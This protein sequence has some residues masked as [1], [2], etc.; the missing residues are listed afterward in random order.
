MSWDD[1]DDDWD[2]SDSEI[3]ARL[4]L[5]TTSN[6]AV[7]SKAPVFDDEEEDL[8]LIEQERNAK[9]NQESLR[10]KGKTLMKK[11]Q[12]ELDR[13][14][15]EELARKAMELEAEMEANM[16]IDE[17]R[18]ME[19]R[20]VEEADNA[21]TDDL[22]GAVESVRGGPGAGKG[23][24]AG[25][26][27]KMKDLK[28]HLKHARKVA[29][30]LTSNG[31][32]HLAT[33]FFKECIQESKD[34]LDDDAITDIIKICNVIKNEKLQ[35]AKR[36]VKGQAQKSKKKDKVAEKKAK[37]M[38]LEIYGDNDQCD[39]YDNFGADYEDDFF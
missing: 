23:M 5:A 35:A 39:D 38:A 13:K 21:L 16:T 1:S 12:A 26:T 7:A 11:K 27:V 24:E 3:D 22:F 34:I 29:Q 2:K 28:D 30:C 33:S 25:D 9:V 36:K 10:S 6:T 37:K 8:T 20:R 32:V 4:G 31:K 19:Q 15:E 17:R 14:E 18:A